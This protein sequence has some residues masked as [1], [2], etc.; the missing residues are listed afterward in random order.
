MTQFF[1]FTLSIVLLATL[2]ACASPAQKSAMIV[3]VT[4]DTVI[5]KESP[6]LNAVKITK[7]SGGESTNPAWTS[8]IGNP[9]FEGALRDSLA[10]HAMLAKSAGR[11]ALTA[12]IISVDQPLF[13]ASL[14]VTSKVKYTVIE[15]SSGKVIFEKEFTTPYTASFSDAFMAVERLRLAN[16]GTVR[17][18]VT[19]FLREL[20]ASV[21]GRK[22]HSLRGGISMADIRIIGSDL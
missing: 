9:E 3:E 16:E 11:F 5:D 14:T 17:E 6:L 12:Q 8:E 19:I 2:A 4:P 18:N 10:N 21:S 22:K 13:G 20:I 7:V 1:K 15:K